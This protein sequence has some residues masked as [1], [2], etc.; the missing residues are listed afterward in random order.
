MPTSSSSNTRNLDSLGDD[1][2]IKQCREGDE[3][4]FGVLWDRHYSAA[5]GAARG[6]S[7]TFD[8]E[9]LV[10]EAFTRILR[11]I[12]NGGGPTGPLRPYLYQTVR[13]TAMRWS[14]Q[15]RPTLSFDALSDRDLSDP[16]DDF[17]ERA[18][19]DSIMAKAYR[20][21]PERWRSVLWYIEI[22]GIPAVEAAP[23]L[24]LSANGVAALAYR[25]REGLRSE[26]LNAHT[27]AANVDPECRWTIARLGVMH[28]K[29]LSLLT[30][31]RIHKH[32]EDCL[33]CTLIS[34]ELES[35]STRL[36][37][38]LVPLTALGTSELGFFGTPILPSLTGGPP[39]TLGASTADA[40]AAPGEGASASSPTP[41]H[42]ASGA[43][44]A[45]MLAGVMATAVVL[46]G[47]YVAVSTLGAPEST[48]PAVQHRPS[49]DPLSAS[50]KQTEGP[51]SASTSPPV[52]VP[53]TPPDEEAPIRP[54]STVEAGPTPPITPPSSSRIAPDET[55]VD[56]S[57]QPPID[58]DP[59][60]T[61]ATMASTPTS[62]DVLNAP[63]T[64]RLYAAPVVYGRTTPSGI[65]SLV[66]L[67]SNEGNLSF[68][69]TVADSDG[70]WSTEVPL[71][72]GTPQKFN[73][74]VQ[75]PD[76]K[77]RT[78]GQIGPYQLEVPGLAPIPEAWTVD[79]DSDGTYDDISVS[80][81][82]DADQ[83]VEAMVDSDRSGTVV[84][85]SDL[86]SQGPAAKVI[87][88]DLAA[89]EHRLTLR[90]MTASG[91]PGPSVEFRF[92][93]SGQGHWVHDHSH[94]ILW[95][96]RT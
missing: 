81:A 90:Y 45:K 93:I 14:K 16:A 82:V 40:G 76:G 33:R 21:L 86:D 4:A 57:E 28:R 67:D 30:G 44:G 75:E 85:F 29:R 61:G 32:L 65:I 73:V 31:E 13:N 37:L 59:L 88:D 27:Q 63:P 25:A 46:A 7:S 53:D 51:G 11:T 47:G 70:N 22:E 80:I 56:T 9:D 96:D 20:N 74:L 39:A 50:P 71:E 8:P 18:L 17:D 23:M 92:F 83:R 1:A 62:P 6:F 95:G 10:Q 49:S 66:R 5:I 68:L 60:V 94:L 43:F 58:T 34:S 38:I 12:R 26:W 87:V 91:K 78:I 54:G 15:A 69:E 72:T 35:L 2:L 55:E 48:S 77:S 19:E 84:L 89:G 36:P 24:G 3:H 41:G 42:G 64:G 79:R 52:A